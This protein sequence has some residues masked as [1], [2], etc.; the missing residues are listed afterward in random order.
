MVQ[1]VAGQG[2][3]IN[4]AAANFYASIASMWLTAQCAIAP[5]YKTHGPSFP[6]D[7]VGVAA[8]QLLDAAGVG[9]GEQYVSVH[10]RRGKK[11]V[12]APHLHK[13]APLEAVQ[14][15]TQ[16]LAGCVGAKHVLVMSEDQVGGGTGWWGWRWVWRCV[17]V[18]VEV[19]FEVGVGVGLEVGVAV[20]LFVVV[21][22]GWWQCEQFWGLGK[23]AGVRASALQQKISDAWF[24][25]LCSI[26]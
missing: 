10:I 18:G 6:Q 15:A 8:Q 14:R 24:T 7:W 3:V 19:G 1:L 11:V 25:R 13:L 23:A 16:K 2:L 4:G 22:I 26:V 17:G 21:R 5:C 9:R 12:E 20:M